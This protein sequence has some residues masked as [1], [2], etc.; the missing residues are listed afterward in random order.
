MDYFGNGLVRFFFTSG[1]PFVI[2]DY[3][4]SLIGIQT[5]QRG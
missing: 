1:R 2:R 4:A 3:R 5:T